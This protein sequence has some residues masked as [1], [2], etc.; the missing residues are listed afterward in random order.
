MGVPYTETGYNM[1]DMLS[2]IQKAIRRGNYELAGWG[3]QQLQGRFRTVMWNRMFVISSEDCYGILTKEL[4]ALRE[5]D[6]R[7]KD[8][9]NIAKAMALLCRSMKSRDACYFSC[10]FIL[11]S[12]LSREIVIEEA[13]MKDFHFR[14][15]RKDPKAY[16]SFGFGQMTMFGEAQEQQKQEPE[17]QEYELAGYRL[18][19]AIGHRD[20]DMIGWYIDKLRNDHRDYLWDVLEDYALYQIDGVLTNEVS[21]LRKA[22]QI[23]NGRRGKGQKDEIFISKAAMLM[24]YAND[25]HF[26]SICSSDMV[27]ELRLVQWDGIR[28]K[29]ISECK[30]EGGRIPEYVFDCHTIRGKKA[31]KTDWDMT[32]DEQEALY[33]LQR[34][35][36]SNASWIYTY[37]Q[38]YREGRMDDA[39]M[40]PIREFAKTHPANP[41]APYP[42]GPRPD[43]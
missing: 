19:V 36:F 13:R 3:A 18:Q 40:A 5:S 1:Y 35:Y 30:L 20:M 24:C 39:A 25:M 9:E 43:C 11:D 16:D 33:P 29:P 34:D 12:R 21:A 17:Y 31:G 32:R 26:E 6:D 22:D 14:T 41:V 28:V 7:K 10:N 23:V 4:V 37:E 15:G 38:D 27:D 42:Y 8:N 2:T